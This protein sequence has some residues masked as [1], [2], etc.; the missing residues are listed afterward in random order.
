MTARRF[1]VVVDTRDHENFSGRL[2]A[3]FALGSINLYRGIQSDNSMTNI[4]KNLVG[5]LI[6]H[7]VLQL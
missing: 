6:F 2:F 5:F 3:R 1:A 4:I 7:F